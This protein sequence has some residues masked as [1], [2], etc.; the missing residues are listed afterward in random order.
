M[1]PACVR[2]RAGSASQGRGAPRAP[3]PGR[4]LLLVNALGRGKRRRDRPGR[5]AGDRDRRAP[6]P[7]TR[8]ATRDGQRITR[9]QMLGMVA[10]IAAAVD[11]PG[12]GRHGGRL[13]RLARGRAQ[14]RL[15]AYSQPV[16]SAS[17]SR[18]PRRRPEPL[19]AIERFVAK[20]VA[21]RAV[22]RARQGVPLVLNARTDVFIGGVGDPGDPARPR[23][24][25]R[26]AYLTPART[27]SSCPRSPTRPRSPLSC[28]GIDGPVSVLAGA[29]SPSIAELAALGVARISVG[30]G[31]YRAALALAR[32]I[33]E[34]AYERRDAR[35][36]DRSTRSPFAEVESLLED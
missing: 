15:A 31:P 21:V 6:A 34:G 29:G 8:S 17:T 10:T 16:P 5:C 36:H 13:R 23:R 28:E 18:T 32:R 20:I 33:A 25:A 22:V 3:R 19:L 9:E 12:H 7:R 26:A 24:R 2:S 35:R 27:A 4:P 1:S 30:S 14:L 11:R